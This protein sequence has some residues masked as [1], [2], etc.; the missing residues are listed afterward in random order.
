MG[1]RTSVQIVIGGTIKSVDDFNKLSDAVVNDG[2]G[3]E[4]GPA[5]T[6]DIIEAMIEASQNGTPVTF[7]AR[8]VNYGDLDEIEEACKE[9]GLDFLKNHAAG[10][11]YGAAWYRYVASEKATLDTS[12]DDQSGPS[13]PLGHLVDVLHRVGPDA[14]ATLVRETA[15]I[16][17]DPGPLVIQPDVMASLGAKV[18][19]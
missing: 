4:W 5:S 7:N 8:G 15:A 1:D 6:A 11:D 9:I 19:G 18:E 16:F 14:L 2:A 12:G 10:G 17:V 13:L 3:M